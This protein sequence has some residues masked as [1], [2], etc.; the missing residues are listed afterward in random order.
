VANR[1]ISVKKIRALLKSI[2]D[3]IRGSRR[4]SEY[5]G[6]SHTKVAS[7]IRKFE[8]SGFTFQELLELDDSALNSVI[9]PEE[10]K[11]AP[12]KNLPDFEA[13]ENALCS[14]K[15]NGVTRT[16][17]WM[18]YIERNPDGYGLSQFNEHYRRFRQ[19]TKKSAMHQDRIPGE[20]MYE[21]Y[22]GL[23]MHFVNRETG[24]KHDCEL[25]VS[26]IGLSGK[27]YTE[28]TLTQQIPDWLASNENAFLFYGGVPWLMIPDCLK[29]AV[30]KG[31]KYDPINNA[32]FEEFCDHYGTVIFPARPGEARDKGLVE[33][34]VKM[35][36]MWVVAPLRNRTFF[37]LQELNEAIWE[38]LELFNNKEFTARE[39]S[40]Q[41][42]FEEHDLP[43]LKPLPA[44]RFEYAEWKGC[45]VGP[46]YHIEFKKCRY[47]VHHDNQGKEV[48]VRVSATGVEIFYKN[49]R[50]ASHMRLKGKGNISTYS[51]HMPPHHLAYKMM[52]LTI[53]RW[54]E[55]LH[56]SALLLAREMYKQEKYPSCS[57]RL[58]FG[59]VKLENIFGKEAFEKACGYVLRYETSYRYRTVANTLKH[60]LY[61]QTDLPFDEDEKVTK[62]KN[63]RGGSYFI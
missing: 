2:I 28:A 3:G 55:S 13:I 16:L 26:A 30:T 60:K 14:G 32:T 61:N 49:E 52:P 20:R 35:V 29:S 59:M 18:E 10:T 63:I 24:E 8:R 51:E 9:Y 19:Q 47:S 36:Q 34:A 15:K 37:S 43:A 5:S 41:S 48:D 44:E 39:G 54:L 57:V 62:H 56:G 31:H 53:R 27:I 22:S 11:P 21:D 45:K 38:K 50:I 6:I 23:K 42:Q 46:D 58:L 17:L 4:L 12:K 7:L 25:F 1:R 40:R 33:N